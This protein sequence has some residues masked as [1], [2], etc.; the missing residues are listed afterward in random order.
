[1]ATLCKSYFSEVAARYAVE[2]LTAAGVPGRDIRLV[3]G[4][5]LRDVCQEPVGGFAGATGPDAP[6]GSFANVRRSRRQ[7]HGSFA[8]VRGPQRQGSFADTDREV[9]VRDGHG[10]GRPRVV[11]DV[12]L[13]RLLRAAGL[14]DDAG[15][16]VVDELHLGRAVVV[17]EV[18]EIA[19]GDARARLEHAAHAA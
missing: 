15:D 1:M 16:S 8:S 13:R 3:T 5:Q 17:A 2:A 18:A 14:D 9:T 6:I 19:P 4:R 10:A 11:G 7:G 12:R